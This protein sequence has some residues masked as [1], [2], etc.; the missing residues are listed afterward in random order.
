MTPYCHPKAN[1][2]DY[3]KLGKQIDKMNQ[4]LNALSLEQTTMK[5]QLAQFNTAMNEQMAQLTT[6]VQQLVI[7][8]A[9]SSTTRSYRCT[10]NS[11]TNSSSSTASTGNLFGHSRAT[12]TT[13][14]TLD[15][16]ASS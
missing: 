7:Q 12:R 16:L 8:S 2:I 10:F 5:A 6:L 13:A 1:S 14:T 15:I 4:N 9:T 3:I 11:A